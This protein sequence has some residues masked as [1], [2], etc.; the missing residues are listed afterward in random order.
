MFSNRFFTNRLIS[1]LY[2][3]VFASK[4]NQIHQTAN[5]SFECIIEHVSHVCDILSKITDHEDKPIFG[6]GSRLINAQSDRLWFSISR[7][8]YF[9][10]INCSAQITAI[11]SIGSRFF[12]RRSLRLLGLRSSRASS[13]RAIETES[14]PKEKHGALDRPP[15]STIAPP[16]LHFRL[17]SLSAA[18]FQPPALSLSLFLP[19]IS[20]PPSYTSSLLIHLPIY[21]SGY[22]RRRSS[23]FISPPHR[24]A[25][26]L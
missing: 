14:E 13:E 7:H 25:S 8:L 20:P 21:L 2:P 17:P 11:L 16:P 1:S 9:I 12:D 19:S 24:T 4:F 10:L 22:L 23:L 15:K 5:F 26:S 3:P 18:L 6:F